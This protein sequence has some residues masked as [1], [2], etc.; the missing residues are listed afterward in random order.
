MCRAELLPSPRNDEEPS[1]PPPV[2]LTLLD[3]GRHA[4]LLVFGAEQPVEQAPLE[5][6]SLGEAHLERGVDLLL[7][8]DRGERR[9][10]SDE[11]GRL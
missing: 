10:R 11:L 6:N 9:H 8:S 3:E 2:S 1:P 4:F 5:I 7:G